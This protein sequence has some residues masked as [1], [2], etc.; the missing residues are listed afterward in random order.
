MVFAVTDAVISV[1]AGHNVS[2]DQDLDGVI[3]IHGKFIFSSV[4]NPELA[5]EYGQKVVLVRGIL[6]IGVI[7]GAPGIPEPVYDA[8]GSGARSEQVLA[9]GIIQ[10][11]LFK[12]ELILR[13]AGMSPVTGRVRTIGTVFSTETFLSSHGPLDGDPLPDAVGAVTKDPQQGLK[14]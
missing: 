4:L 9:D 5:G 14:V 12:L 8:A 13:M 7:V 2:V 10:Y 3:P 11:Q 6:I 1:P